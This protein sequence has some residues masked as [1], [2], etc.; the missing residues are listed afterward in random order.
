MWRCRLIWVKSVG[1]GWT[2]LDDEAAS[3]EARHSWHQ[4][5]PA[6]LV[7]FDLYS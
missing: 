7:I 3:H 2:T 4:D 1:Q 6:D 5:A